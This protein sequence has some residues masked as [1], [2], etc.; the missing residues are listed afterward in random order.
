MSSGKLRK[1]ANMVG[2]LYASTGSVI[3]SGWLFGAMH[4]AQQAGPLSLLS[5][6]IGGVAILLLALVYAELATMIP[7][8]GALVHLSHLS[9]GDLLGKIW[10][11]VLILGYT[12]IAPVEVAAVLTYAN[13]Y[14][15]G[16]VAPKSGLL[17]HTGFMVAIVVL[18]LFIGLNLLT[19]RWVMRINTAA[20]WWK[21]AIPVATIG[22]LIAF[23]HHTENLHAAPMSYH[24]DGIFTAVAS[25]GVVFSFL[26]FRTAIDLAGETPNPGRNIPIAVVGTVLLTLVIYVA[27]QYAFIVALNPG[28]LAGGWDKLHFA[29]STG[30]LAAIATAIGAAWW[31]VV[32]Y[33]DAIVSPA[34]TGFIFATASSRIIMAS[35][36]TGTLPKSMAGVN[37]NGAPTTAL[38]VCFVIGA[39]YFLPF[40]SWQKLVN[41][42][43]SAFVLSYG[44]GPIVLLH[45]RRRMPE[46]DRPFTLKGAWIVAP[47]AFI[48]S[49]WIILWT[50]FKTVSFLFGLIAVFM[51]AYA[52]YGLVARKA[53]AKPQ[54]WR[55]IAWLITYF[56][57][58]WVFSLVGPE[59]MGGMDYLNLWQAMFGLALFSLFVLWL[60]LNTAL[61][62]EESRAWVA[63]LQTAEAPAAP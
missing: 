33:A 40:P 8:S 22:I 3:G 11:W 5:W 17:T 21:L 10:S 48:V 32:L 28:D 50:G 52:V 15:P 24:V 13:N 59:S 38:L 9:H 20:T 29:G 37:G 54:G 30:P 57:G 62:A 39:L 2:L 42:I 58:L 56:I 1:E 51:L 55:H 25:A 23:S 60:S 46:A 63:E 31:A 18:A 43:S 36:E 16:L 4:A 53:D 6:I 45:L 7:R 41:Y 34:G 49:N 44:I 47:I 12:A 19:I 26:G 61:S 14:L 35:G 27:L